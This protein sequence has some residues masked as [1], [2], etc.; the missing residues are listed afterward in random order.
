LAVDLAARSVDTQIQL[1]RALG[2]GFT[3]T[4]TTS[5]AAPTSDTVVR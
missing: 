4:D 3:D 5:A 1:I 2:G